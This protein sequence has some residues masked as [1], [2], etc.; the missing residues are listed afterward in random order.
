[1]CWSVIESWYGYVKCTYVH[2]MFIRI[3]IKKNKKRNTDDSLGLGTKLLLP[4]LSFGFRH[5]EREAQFSMLTVRPSSV[6]P[7]N[8]RV[9]TPQS[10][11]WTGLAQVRK[12]NSLRPASNLN[13]LLSS[14]SLRIPAHRFRTWRHSY[15][16]SYFLSGV[17]TVTSAI[18]KSSLHV[19]EHLR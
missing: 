4:S 8:A 17:F 18:V 12:I 5:K 2:R 11:N 14:R 13:S 3:G 16:L 1:M 7:I 9:H 10:T 19:H 15:P 6:D